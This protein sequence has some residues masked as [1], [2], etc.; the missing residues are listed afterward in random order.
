MGFFVASSLIE[1][2]SF[3][4]PA[5]ACAYL[6]PVKVIV[7]SPSWVSGL[8]S[9]VVKIQVPWKGFSAAGTAAVTV[10]GFFWPA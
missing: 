5:T 3:T 2:R 1:P 9:G 10:G 6:S 8:P 4:V 7:K